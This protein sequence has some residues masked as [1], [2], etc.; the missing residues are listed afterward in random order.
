MSPP[1]SEWICCPEG[2]AFA[3]TTALLKTEQFILI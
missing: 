1:H 3:E 2:M